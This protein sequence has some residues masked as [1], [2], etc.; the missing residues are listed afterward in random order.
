[1]FLKEIKLRNFRC[2]ADL[3]IS[4][5]Q[6]GGGIRKWTILLGENGSGKSNLLKGVALITAGSDALPELLGEPDEW[7][8]Y[9][10]SFCEL[11]ATMV[12]KGADER[13]IKLRINRGDGPSDVILR[14]QDSLRQLDDAIE[15]AERNYFVVGYGATRHLSSERSL[16]GERK[17]SKLGRARN[18]V[19]LFDPD[20]LLMP[21]ESW[22]MDLDY[23]NNR[24]GMDTVRKV[25][26]SFLREVSFSRINKKKKQ[27]LFKTRFGIVP[28]H[29]LSDGYQNVASWVGDLL[30]RVSETF[31]DYKAP[32][33]ARGL[34]LIDEIDLHLHPRW[35]RELLRF[36]DRRL[37]NLQLIV[38][39]HSPITAQQ[40][41]KGEL[42]H[43]ERVGKKIR[44]EVFEGE[45]KSL[46]LH[47]LVMSDLFG[48]ASDESFETETKKKEFR[49]LRDKGKLKPTEKKKLKALTSELGV[50]PSIQR[51]HSVLDDEQT[52]LLRRIE[53]E[54]K[55]KKS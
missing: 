3:A 30:Y 25:L 5:V 46:L 18:V 16:R 40:A 32:L 51:S 34:L 19:T 4:F 42:H 29:V 49:K 23:R 9:Q 12:T 41:D 24:A 31:D 2:F 45:P 36:V 14:N 35:Q 52:K 1:M 54:L 37:P 47:Q 20:A 10:K 27:L 21:L 8:Q 39:T 26:T 33:K 7:I 28:M 44:L 6:E 22:A 38:T 50:L 15:H 55:E 11:E 48:L 17:K 13:Q 53:K 43:L